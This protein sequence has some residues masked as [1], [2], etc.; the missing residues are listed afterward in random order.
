MVPN[1]GCFLRGAL[2][3][4]RSTQS[5]R[6]RPERPTQPSNTTLA[7]TIQEPGNAIQGL[8]E[9][10]LKEGTDMGILAFRPPLCFRGSTA[11]F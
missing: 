7:P 9:E 6:L 1:T 5:S 2:R 8:E 3:E 4:Q 11:G 10:G